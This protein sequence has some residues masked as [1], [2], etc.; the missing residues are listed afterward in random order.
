[1]D[2]T[3]MTDADLNMLRIDVLEEQE[4]RANLAH[5]P[6][7]I[8]ELADKFRAGGGDESAL[9]DAITAE[10]LALLAEQA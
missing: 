5:I 7:Q 2:L 9:A 3:T 4:R 8:K 6:E 1:M 10:Q